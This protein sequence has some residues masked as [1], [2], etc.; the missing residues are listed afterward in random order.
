VLKGQGARLYAT[1]LPSPERDQRILVIDE[2]P[3]GDAAPLSAA[4]LT[5]REHQVLDL[6]AAGRSNRDIAIQL[7]VSIRTVHKHLEHLYPKLG[8]HD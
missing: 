3:S 6:V 5:V 8:V 1:L 2:R 4:G 7:N